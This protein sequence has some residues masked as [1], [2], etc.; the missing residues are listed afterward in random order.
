MRDAAFLQQR[1]VVQLDVLLLGHVA[2]LQPVEQHA[3]LSPQRVRRT[4][5]AL[6]P[7]DPRPETLEALAA[8]AGQNDPFDAGLGCPQL[9]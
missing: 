9:L 5:A 2:Q 7:E 1:R 3:V 6:V 4:R 8:V